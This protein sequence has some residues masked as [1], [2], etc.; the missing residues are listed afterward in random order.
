MLTR[1]RP[2]AAALLAAAAFASSLA[3]ASLTGPPQAAQAAHGDQSTTH[4]W[5]AGAFRAQTVI[6]SH[7]HTNY[8]TCGRAA[9]IKCR[10]AGDVVTVAAD[11]RTGT[12]SCP[13]QIFAT[14]IDCGHGGGGVWTFN[15]HAPDP[16]TTTTVMWCDPDGSGPAAEALTNADAS[17][18]GTWTVNAPACPAGDTPRESHRHASG[19]GA[20]ADCQTHTPS[21]PACPTPAPA[22]SATWTWN[23]GQGHTARS[24][25]WTGCGAAL[26]PACP[27]ADTPTSAHRHTTGAHA[28]CRTHRPKAPPCP[29][30][31]P[32]SGTL[33]W[34]WAPPGGGHS[35]LVRQRACTPQPCRAGGQPWWPVDVM[36]AAEETAQWDLRDPYHDTGTGANWGPKAG[37]FQRE[38]VRRESGPGE[39]YTTTVWEW[40]SLAGLALGPQPLGSSPEGS[41]HSPVSGFRLAAERSSSDLK[42]NYVLAAHRN[43]RA[44]WLTYAAARDGRRYCGNVQSRHKGMWWKLD[45][46]K[47]AEGY[48]S[49]GSCPAESCDVAINLADDS[50]S[51][52]ITVYRDWEMKVTMGRRTGW[53]A[54]SGGGASGVLRSDHF[55]IDCTSRC[56]DR[57]AMFSILSDYRRYKNL[58]SHH[59]LPYPF[60]NYMRC[61]CAWIE[62]MQSLNDISSP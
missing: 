9:P 8:W 61:M 52:T 20:H 51:G 36:A 16:P 13:V 57:L 2:S 35:S 19:G 26:L 14:V 49:S 43:S 53:R 62:Y 45:G 15:Y 42:N 21:Q 60:F 33:T 31:A 32:A 17:H 11:G 46:A 56:C 44:G 27:A 1:F 47:P 59:G 28:D 6:A 54:P 25:T 23:P 10:A 4:T 34:S 18:C 38:T 5:A 48:A 50:P 39:Y 58:F 7:T 29:T 30:P 55:T 22:A 41:R 12:A 24:M 3:A 40:K 37:K